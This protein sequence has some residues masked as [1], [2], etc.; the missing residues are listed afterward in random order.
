MLLELGQEQHKGRFVVQVQAT[1]E[2]KAAQA[3]QAMLVGL[4][5]Q[6]SLV[7]LAA[8]ASLVGLADQARWG[9]LVGRAILDLLPADYF[10]VG[11]QGH[12]KAEMDYNGN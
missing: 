4:A 6:A 8:Q 1:Q 11:S 9:W 2:L 10:A 5:A 12:L 7:G 3:V